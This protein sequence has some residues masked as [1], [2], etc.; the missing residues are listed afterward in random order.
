MGYITKNKNKKCYIFDE[1][2]LT[3]T[4][5]T[6]EQYQE[7]FGPKTGILCECIDSIDMYMLQK[8]RFIKIFH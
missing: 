4:L 1:H 2:D 6:F 7:M 8:N 3:E 5:I